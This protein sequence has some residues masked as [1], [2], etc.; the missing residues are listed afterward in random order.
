MN[1]ETLLKESF[2]IRGL[3]QATILRK[4]TEYKRFM[5][6]LDDK[7]LREVDSTFLEGYIQTLKEEGFSR[8]TLNTAMAFLKDFF[9][10]LH[11]KDYILSNPLSCTEIV[12]TER[13]GIKAVL[14]QEEVI[15]FLENIEP[16][17]GIGIRDRAMF[18]LLY[19]TGMRG[20]ELINLDVEHLDLKAGEVFIKQ[21]KNRK[22]RI[23]P[24]GDTAKKFVS[25]WLNRARRWF[26]LQENGPV[27]TNPK[28][29]RLALSSLQSRFNYWI[30]QANLM[31]RGFT[32]HSLRHSCAT[33]LLENG[34]D[35]RYV[36]ELLGHESIETTAEYTKD[37]MNSIKRIHRTYHPRENEIYPEDV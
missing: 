35:I 28:G 13:A 9:T 21:G 7:D 32:T 33:H 18:E 19:L 2:V 17:T 5:I 14:N 6:Y 27:F 8:S 4:F 34:A 36:Q 26:C 23:V 15:Q 29:G 11:R 16:V 25:L 12:I 37:I 22:D 30:K 10:L 3:S 24:L 1:Y 20:R 31:N